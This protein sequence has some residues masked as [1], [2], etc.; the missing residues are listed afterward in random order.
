MCMR[1][2]GRGRE[3][4]GARARARARACEG[5]RAR[6]HVQGARPAIGPLLEACMRRREAA[7]VAHRQDGRVEEMGAA[8]PLASLGKQSRSRLAGRRVAG[9]C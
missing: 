5:A 1:G 4:E 2:Q 3:G 9:S 6:A 7:A 8:P